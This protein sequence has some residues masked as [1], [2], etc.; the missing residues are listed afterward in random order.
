MTARFDF[1][2][3]L[4]YFKPSIIQPATHR[5]KTVSRPSSSIS[6]F[7]PWLIAALLVLAV[8]LRAEVWI[9]EILFNPPATDFPNEYVE[10]RGT[11]NQVL[12]NGTY[13]VAVEGDT[14]GNPGTIQNVFDLSGRSLSGNG[15]LL[16]LQNSNTYVFHSN[17]VALVNTNGPGFG[18]G[19]SHPVRHRGEGGQTD[20]ENNSVTFFLIQSPSYPVINDDIDSNNDGT[21]DGVLYAVWTVIDAVAVLDSD[22]AG[23]FGYG[24]I[25]FRRSTSPGNGATVVSGTIVPVP[26]TP[27]YVGRSGHTTN[28]TA[29]A[30]VASGGLS[31]SAPS[32]SL[33]STDTDPAA[34][35]GRPLNHIGGPNF[36]VALLHGVV[37]RES[38]GGTEL[39][40]GGAGTDSYT[41]LLNT[42]PSGN[43]TVRI[44][45]AP[46]LEISTDAGVSFGTT[47][48]VVFNNTSPVTVLVRVLDDMVV[49]T[50][51]HP[52]PI[53]H[54]IIASADVARYPLN[55]PLPQVN[56]S[57]ME[58][59]T[60]L[61]S[62]LKVN[63]P[64]LEDAPYEFIEL[65]GVPNATLTNVYFLAIESEHGT[66]SGTVNTVIDLS[67]ERLGAAGLLLIVA[68]GHPYNV[69]GGARVFLAAELG[70]PGGG[71][72]NGSRSFLLVSSPTPLVAGRDL[73]SGDNGTLEG[74]PP[75][76]T[77]LDSVAWL[78]SPNDVAYSPAQLTQ[79]SGIPDA[80]TR[81]PGNMNANFGPA[82]VNGNLEGEDGAGLVY[83][84]TAASTNLPYGTVLTPG[85]VNN[86]APKFTGLGPVSSVIGDPTT[87]AISFQ[88]SDAETPVNLLNIFISCSDETIVP[89]ANII[90][91]GTGSDR[92]LTITPVAV[93]Y[94]TILLSTSDGDMTGLAAIPYAA[95]VD[96]LGG[97][98]FH[99]GV[100]DASAA[101]ALDNAYMLVGDDENQVLRVFNRSNSGP[102]VV[103]FNLNPFLE[104]LDLYGN[105][106]PREID[107]EGATRVGDRLYWIGSHSHNRDSESRT[108]RGRLFATDISG[109]ATN[110]SLTF[111]GRY[112]FLKN[113]LM[114]W[115]AGNA[116]GRGADYY[117]LTASGTTGIDPKAIDGSGFNIEGLTMAPGS[118]TTAYVCF[119]APF[120]PAANRVKALVVPVLNLA[121]LV[122]GGFTNPGAAQFGA[123][124]ELN[125][126]GRGIR[127]MEGGNSGYL[128]VAGPPGL[129]NGTP[130]SDF[131]LFTWSGQPADPVQERGVS[132]AGLIPEGLVELPPG[133][134][135]ENSR[136]QLISDNGIALYY[137]DGVEAKFLPVPQFKKFRSDW[138]TLGPVVMSQPV[139]KSMQRIGGACVLTWYS[140]A[141]QNYRVQAKSAFSEP[142]WTDVPGDVLATD[143]LAS[144]MISMDAHPHKF[145]R[146]IIP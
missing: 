146:I 39:A 136:V 103:G 60:V 67:G 43:V 134:W 100:S 66:N 130:P 54:A 19:G 127:S 9:S 77:V 84:G 102:A 97:G 11:P 99:A 46:P 85:R 24:K 36:G 68:D 140:V 122:T 112:D 111:V 34:Y 21:P 135:T 71:L 78:G 86:T 80:A 83:D 6:G 17:A 59:D 95:S 113:D 15:F 92:T 62:E 52:V 144:K 23:D 90:M 105:G 139:F 114:N 91:S 56:V 57:V 33:D 93:G 74:L 126:G 8:T 65:R 94:A 89:L 145:F 121:A 30:W 106:T 70:L 132:L 27:N 2:F 133:P 61:L 131:R 44:T 108:N 48:N 63:P 141:G 79:S 110:L 40:E 128:I 109:P 51:P 7:T 107:L 96:P 125:L 55:S 129:A 81:F 13:L 1:G 75:G 45:A 35:A 116:H 143:A 117:G 118:V 20:L 101:L 115:D 32:W 16:L 3:I 98:I 123:P 53:S 26:F 25:N 41:L 124:I 69:P 50:Q 58:N 138:R 4:A 64:G 49:D 72:G 38:G 42:V 88:I 142:A 137:G 5:I 82:W 28:W 18:S 119:R 47:R 87:P 76:T 10:L 22:G 120:I 37:A 14:N 104:L 31:G 29:S 12:T 73:D